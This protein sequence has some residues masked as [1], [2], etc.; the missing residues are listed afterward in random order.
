MSLPTRE[1]FLLK[2]TEHQRQA[3]QSASAQ[4]CYTIDEWCQRRRVSRAMFYKLAKLGKA[5]RTYYVG[6][7]RLISDQADAAWMRAQEAEADQPLDAA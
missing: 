3:R 1:A 7:R 5:P 6:T 4:A 2:L